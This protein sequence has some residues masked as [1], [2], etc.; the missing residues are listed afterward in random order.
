MPS[1]SSLLASWRRLPQP[2]REAVRTASILEHTLRRARACPF[3]F[4]KFVF[5]AIP[6]WHTPPDFQREW[7]ALAQ[8]PDDLHAIIFAPYRRGKTFWFAKTL[9]LWLMGTWPESRGLI[10][11]ETAVPAQDRLRAI[12][13]LIES[14][15]TPES[16][17]LH[18]VFPNLRP[19]R[20]RGRSDIWSSTALLVQRNDIDKD[21]TL[22]AAGL[23][24]GGLA[25]ARLD[26]M[27]LDNVC[28]KKT[29]LSPAGRRAVSTVFWNVYWPRLEKSGQAR[30]DV[31]GVNGG[32]LWAID[33]AWNP[34]DIMHELAEK[35]GRHTY[36]AERQPGDSPDIRVA[37]WP[38]VWGEQQMEYDRTHMTG[39]DFARLHLCMPSSES[40]TWFDSDAL[41]RSI[42]DSLEMLAGGN[43]DLDGLTLIAGLDPAT[44][45]GDH[46]D[47]GVL[48]LSGYDKNGTDTCLSIDKGRWDIIETM[49][50][51]IDLK[52]RFP[53]LRIIAVESDGQQVYIV[54]TLRNADVVRAVAKRMDIEEQ[55]IRHMLATMRVVKTRTGKRGKHD[56]DGIKGMSLGFEVGKRRGP[57]HPLYREF[58][59]QCEV[60]TPEAHTGDILSAAYHASEGLRCS[61]G[62]LG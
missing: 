53:D 36:R 17:R 51:I 15:D 16:K 20:R 55:E 49:R 37:D 31:G 11:C 24:T 33:T 13:S 5:G 8:D 60:W 43:G 52:V 7:M 9:P 54:Q 30:I 58:L 2:H 34:E 29:S 41:Y 57:D 25:G 1:T 14:N 46:G 48:W 59:K 4:G 12:G 18:M 27:V 40:A 56:P 21:P 35:F 38:A 45:E 22:Q 42:D 23:E 28:G 26:W 50:R 6:D 19:E 10:G 39:R 44:G 3:F 61:R 47:E 62:P 32:R